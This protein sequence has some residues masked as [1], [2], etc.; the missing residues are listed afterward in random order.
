[1]AAAIRN[2]YQNECRRI[3]QFTELSAYLAKKWSQ[4]RL[5]MAA[6][7]QRVL[8]NQAHQ[9]HKHVQ[10]QLQDAQKDKNEF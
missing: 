1:M 5:K 10:N 9:V 8:V 4:L 2:A 6:K 7:N 3:A